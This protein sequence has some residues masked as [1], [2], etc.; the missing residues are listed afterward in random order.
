MCINVFGR[1]KDVCVKYFNFVTIKYYVVAVFQKIATISAIKR[2]KKKFKITHMKS[3]KV[4][5]IS[6]S[7]SNKTF[8]EGKNPEGIRKTDFSDKY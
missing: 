3:P 1:K 5:D 4:M 2:R 8:R 6:L 7:S